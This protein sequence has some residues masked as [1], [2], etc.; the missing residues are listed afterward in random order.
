MSRSFSEKKSE[1]PQESLERHG[2][3]SRWGLGI[4]SEKYL[5]IYL[6]FSY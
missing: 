5:D 3:D 6:L 4:F 1:T 2:F